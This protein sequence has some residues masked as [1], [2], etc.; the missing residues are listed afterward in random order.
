[1][2][3]KLI[4]VDDHVSES[5]DA[6][7][8]RVPARL[9]DQAPRI[10]NMD[11]FQAWVYDGQVRRIGGLDAVAGRR[12]ED[13]SPDPV[14][15]G[16]Q[17][18]PRAYWD[19]I[20]R[21]KAMDVDGVDCEVLFPGL[22][23]F[24][25]GGFFGVKD[26]ALRSACYGAYND[27]LAEDWRGSNPERFVAQCSLPLYD[28]EESLT[29]LRRSYETGHRSVTFPSNPEGWGFPPL[30]DP[31]WNPLWG[32]IQDLDIPVS[33]H[34][35]GGAPP[36]GQGGP[37][38][39]TVSVFRTGAKGVAQ[40]AIIKSLASNIITLADF[41]FSGVLERFPTLKVVSVESGIGWVPYF[42]EQCDDV[43]QRQRFWTKS[44]LRMLPSQYAA[45]QL[46]WNFWSEKAGLRLLDFIGE[47]H[48]MWESDYPHSICNWPNSWKV[49]ED[50][51]AGIP[52]G[53]KSKILVANAARLYHL[54]LS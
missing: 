31:H 24:G 6:Y 1:M 44:E 32:L 48:V 39:S 17:S 37:M 18:L 41:M 54:S 30:A 28:L 16:Y 12:F 19:P 23:G 47:D 53:T 21:L 34:I 36:A 50:I 29:E 7:Q 49:I 9:R 3:Y 35:G 46:Y 52:A 38:S 43:Y 13:Y 2:R 22:A 25:G 40:A 33:I 20:E 11:G 15:G 42:L 27:H 4:S 8:K 10:V 45:R 14:E 26:P 51:C 5:P